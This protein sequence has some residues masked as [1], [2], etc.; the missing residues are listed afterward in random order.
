MKAPAF[1]EC[2][3]VRLINPGFES[4]QF[5]LPFADILGQV[6]EHRDADPLSAKSGPNEHPLHF[7]VFVVEQFHAAT[8]GRLPA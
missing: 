5:D 6:I 8:P 3:G 7:A 1:V 4:Q 2:D